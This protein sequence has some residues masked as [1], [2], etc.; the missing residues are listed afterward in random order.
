MCTS[1]Y[2]SHI[3]SYWSFR[4]YYID[5]ISIIQS[6]FIDSHGMYQVVVP[7]WVELALDLWT[8]EQGTFFFLR[9]KV[10]VDRYLMPKITSIKLCNMVK[11]MILIYAHT[12]YIHIY[13]YLNIYIYIFIYRYWIYIY[14]YIYLFT[15]TEY[16]CIYIYIY[17]CWIYIY[18]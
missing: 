16:I 7:A 12:E 14:I 5:H 6:I 15:H 13:I 3:E 9:G 18:I 2:T 4:S 10:E 11:H 17:T 8:D 1:Y